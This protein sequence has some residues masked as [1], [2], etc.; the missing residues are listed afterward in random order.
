[1]Y[2]LLLNYYWVEICLKVLCKIKVSLNRYIRKVIIGK[3][4]F[5]F[6]FEVV[7]FL[8]LELFLDVF[9]EEGDWLIVFRYNVVF[10]YRMN[11]F[12]RFR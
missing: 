6:I 5:V 3:R 12:E 1:M 4:V 11:Y 9:S 7:C 10:C 2:K 8:R